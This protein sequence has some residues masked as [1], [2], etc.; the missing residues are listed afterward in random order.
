[1]YSSRPTKNLKL[2]QIS[3]RSGIKFIGTISGSIL[4]AA[5]HAGVLL[6]HS[7]KTGRCSTCKCKVLN[8]KTRELQAEIGLSE[9]DKAEGWILSCVRSVETDVTLEVDNLS[10]IELPIVK[11]IPCRISHLQLLAPDVIQVKLRLPPNTDFKFIPGQYVDVIGPFGVRRSY[12]LANGSFSDKLLELHIRAVEVGVMSEYWFSKAKVDD[13]LRINGPLGTFFL[14]DVSALD[15]VFL[16]T[17]TGFAPV[18]A[19]LETL[20]DLSPEYAP[21]SVTVL[22]GGRKLSDIYYDF[23]K[24]STNF[25]FIP[26]LSRADETWTGVRG[27]VQQQLLSFLPDLSRAAVYACGSQA[28]IRDSQIKLV[29]AG[30]PAN[31]FYADAF[32]S[33]GN[34][35]HIEDN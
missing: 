32:L 35:N 14:R 23:E 18:K 4:D 20:S 3:L 12:S 11:T 6:P 16:A 33:S 21:R 2:P 25:M 15:L 19:I 26:V 7:C 9:Q 13:L 17:G 31:R 27:Y 24:N 5:T 34:F 22:W 29:K 28:M 1:M 30:L 10:G 8:G